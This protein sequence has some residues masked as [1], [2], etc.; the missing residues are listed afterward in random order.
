MASST[1][2]KALHNPDINVY[3]KRLIDKILEISKDCI[4]NKIVTIR[5]SDPPW[6]TSSIK[7]YI[8]KRKRASRRAKQT[9][10]MNDWN[11]F[12]RLRNKTISM[13][14][15]SKKALNESLSDKLKSDSLSPR[16]WWSLLKSFISPS[17]QASS[18]P[19]EKDGL[20]F[21]EEVEK[22][23]VLN[24]FFRD[25]T[26][27]NDHDVALPEI[28]PYLVERCLSSLVLSPDEVKLILK[29]LP[30]GKATGP[31]GLS[32]RILS[33]LADELS[34]PVCAL[35]NQSL[36]HGT[37]PEC[38]KETHVYPILKGGDPAVP[39]NY[40]PISLLSNLDKALER[41]VFKYLYN[42][43]LDN[44]I[45]TSFQS[46]FRP[47]DST[48][49]QLTYLYDTFCHALDSGKEIRVVFCDISKAFDRVWHSGLIHKLK[50]AGV[51]G[52]L[53]QW[54]TSYLENRKQR[55]VL[56]GVKS[57]W[58]YI[59]AGVLQGSILGPLL[60]LL[61]INDI[62]T[63]IRSNIR[64]FADDTSLYIIVDNPDAAAE[65]LN[66]DLNK[67]SKWAKSWLVK[68]NPNKNES[69]IISRKINQPDHPP[70]FMSNQEI[71]EVQFHKHL[72]IYI[73]SDC[74]WHKH[75]E[76]VKSKAWSRI[77]VMR[78]F[79]Y[80][81][82]RKSLETIY[83]AF[84]RPILEYAD[85]V[86]DNCTQQ[87][88]HEIE[89]IQLEAARI[90]TGTTKLVSVQKLYDEIGWETLDVRRRKHK[91]V[92]FYKMYND[93]APSYLSSLV[94]RPDQN[95]S[96][97]S[98]RNA[99]NIRT[100][101]S[102]TNQ[103]YNSFLP[104]AIRDWND[105]PCADRIVDTVDDFKRQLS[106]GRVIVPKY[107][108]AGNR[109][110]QILQTRLRTGCSSLNYDLYSKNIIESPLCN[111]RCGEIENADHFFFRCHLYQNHRQVLMDTL[112]QHGNIT[113]NIILNGDFNLPN[114]ANIA[115]FEAVQRYIQRTKRF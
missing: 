57:I 110:M 104:A 81:L 86:W 60:F 108:Y 111:C 95:A 54:F 2:W 97:Y 67:I 51:T 35:F 83:I 44:N 49:N 5:P 18:P 89:K 114:E 91:L 29:S 45:L 107:F 19:L 72:G 96:R 80:T 71:N 105:L 26:L 78:K 103:Y 27:L 52:N 66:T 22:A 37:V 93:I 106:Q 59:K 3:A 16:Q 73:A 102:R 92:L 36:Q 50:A 39:S 47:G 53:L 10:F 11:T 88:K 85:V 1:D 76:Y 115:I 46:G 68:F 74:S 109:S 58:N 75:I 20:V 69:L 61:Y 17:S 87:E 40:R 55:V 13:I 12:R 84:V 41:L 38:F 9:N 14:R 82:D 43:L 64:L 63:E 24:D 32:N 65:I 112:S 25:Q 8:R 31:D 15:E 48:V 100:I 23:N 94:P 98:L 99:N 90:A 62:V 28:A 6:M 34:V 70:V 56:S 79:K 113:L 77:N 30:V 4:P 101:Q 7:R 42:H 33:V 21:V